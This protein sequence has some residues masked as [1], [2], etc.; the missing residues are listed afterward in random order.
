MEGGWVG[1]GLMRAGDK[2][3]GPG[4]NSTGDSEDTAKRRRASSRRAQACGIPMQRK[5]QPANKLCLLLRTCGLFTAFLCLFL[6][7]DM[8]DSH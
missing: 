7:G 3:E 1:G 6:P 4:G 8:W 2:T 5:L